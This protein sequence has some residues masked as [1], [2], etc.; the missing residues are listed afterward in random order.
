MIAKTTRH[1]VYSN[2]NTDNPTELSYHV[3]CSIISERVREKDEIAAAHE[4]LSPDICSKMSGIS[5]SV[6]ANRTITKC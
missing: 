4:F 1:T 6:P 5:L 3:R 2:I